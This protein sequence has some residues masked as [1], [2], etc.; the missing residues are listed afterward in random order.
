M[1]H[2]LIIVMQLNRKLKRNHILHLCVCVC[3]PH[4]IIIFKYI[5][6][7]E[8]IIIVIA[9]IWAVCECVYSVNHNVEV[10]L[11]CVFVFYGCV[12]LYW[13]PYINVV[14]CLYGYIYIYILSANIVIKRGKREITNWLIECE[15]Q[16][17]N[18]DIYIYILN[19]LVKSEMSQML[20]KNTF[21]MK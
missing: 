13:S 9:I 19:S 5:F 6:I 14:L 10:A 18:A 4:F 2:I 16:W 8:C 3:E 17:R 7:Y 11:E 1:T 20:W 15:S 12:V 21:G